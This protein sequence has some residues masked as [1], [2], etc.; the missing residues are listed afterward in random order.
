MPSFEQP[1]V[2]LAGPAD[3]PALTASLVAA[4]ADDPIVTWSFPRPDR[5][6]RGSSRF[7]ELALEH[8]VPQEVTWTAGDGEGGALWAL[9][10]RWH[11]P[12]MA[13]LRLCLGCAP[14]IGR[15]APRVAWGLSGVERRHPAEPHLYLAVLGVHPSAQGRGLGSALLAP[16]LALC[17]ED[18]LPA[19]LETGKEENLSFYA[20]HGFRVIDELRLPSG[21]RVWR[22]WREPA[23]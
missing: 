21:P 8:H 23:A 1:A 3:V 15:R 19:Y 20:R 7:F 2:R 6:P 22:M 11:R 17:D 9:P 14:S 5:R 4:F 18:R 16:G 12:A 10:G 13:T